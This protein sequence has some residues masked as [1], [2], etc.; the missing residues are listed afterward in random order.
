MKNLEISPGPRFYRRQVASSADD[1][2]LREEALLLLLGSSLPRHG[3]GARGRCPQV[4]VQVAGARR[5]C[6]PPPRRR[7]PPPPPPLLGQTAGPAIAS[8]ERRRPGEVGPGVRARGPIW[9]SV[10]GL[11]RAP[12]RATD[13]RCRLARAGGPQGPA[14]SDAPAGPRLQRDDRYGSSESGRHGRTEEM[15]GQYSGVRLSDR[16]ACACPL[17]LCGATRRRGRRIRAVR[18]AKVPRSFACSPAGRQTRPGRHGQT[19]PGRPGRITRRHRA[20][21][22]QA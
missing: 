20:P 21:P 15:L 7:R 16:L 5:R 3:G 8:D 13:T 14:A 12:R 22:S 10:A 9:P 6:R 11:R 1:E 4:A 2:R 17:S 19:R 18:F